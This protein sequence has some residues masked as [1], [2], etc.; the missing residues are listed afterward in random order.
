MQFKVVTGA[1]NSQKYQADILE[2][3]VRPPLDSLDGQ[4]MV[5]WDDIARPHFIHIIEEYKKSTEQ[6]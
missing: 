5:L 4:N 6:R 3:D 1:L 2:F